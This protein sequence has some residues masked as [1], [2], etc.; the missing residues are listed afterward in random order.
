MAVNSPSS[1][2]MWRTG[3]N[4]SVSYTWTPADPIPVQSWTVDLYSTTPGNAYFYTPLRLLT[5]INP[6]TRSVTFQ[7]PSGSKIVQGNYF[8]WVFG[9]QGAKVGQASGIPFAAKGG[10]FLVYGQYAYSG[11]GSSWF[12]FSKKKKKNGCEKLPFN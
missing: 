4:N 6:I 2:Q 8:A 5:D 3:T 10:A 1:G 11:N 9:F 7:I 12:P